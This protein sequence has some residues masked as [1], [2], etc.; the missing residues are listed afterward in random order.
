MK[1]STVI[2]LLIIPLI[3]IECVALETYIKNEE[4]YQQIIPIENRST[5]LVFGE[6]LVLN[7]YSL[8][9]RNDT[10]NIS[11]NVFFG[12]IETTGR[13]YA[14]YKNK[15]RLYTVDVITSKRQI[16][17]N[18]NNYITINQEMYIRII[19]NTGMK[20]DFQINLDGK[21]PYV[22]FSDTISGEIYFNYYRSR[23]KNYLESEY[24]S[25]TGFEIS[26]NN[27]EFGILAFYPPASLYLK[28]DIEINEKM[29]LYI[30][31]AYAS[32]LHNEYKN[33][34]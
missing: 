23:N 26:K 13:R 17:F 8:H 5:F 7:E 4:N 25:F 21:Q 12:T 20:N 33:M 16:Q 14:F 18:E 2:I 24:E 34:L 10:P 32:F 15:V 28:N 3:F 27:E 9:Y 29:A 6:R 19:D 31:A 11:R 30:L 22:I 1:K